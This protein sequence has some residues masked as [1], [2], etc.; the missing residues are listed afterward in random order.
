MPLT[1][2][3]LAPAWSVFLTA[4]RKWSF[5]GLSIGSV[6]PDAEIPILYATGIETQTGHGIMHSLLGALTF[7]AMLAVLAVYLLYPALAGWW[8]GRFGTKWVHFGGVD[9][10]DI[11]KLP[12]VIA[13]VYA[14]IV[15]HVGVDFLTLQLCEGLLVAHLGQHDPVGSSPCPA[16]H[17]PR[18]DGGHRAREMTEP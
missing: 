6:I 7:D 3:H 18:E 4:R 9:V 2:L 15:L 13:G 14:G 10:G 11:D 12:R 1:P 16:A 17:P 8:E 5:A